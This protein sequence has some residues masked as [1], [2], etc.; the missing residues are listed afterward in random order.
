MANPDVRRA[1]LI[2]SLRV[3]SGPEKLKHSLSTVT[4]I[5]QFQ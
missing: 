4:Y 5:A 3:K 2:G 1:A